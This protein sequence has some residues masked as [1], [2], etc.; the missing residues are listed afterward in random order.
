MNKDTSLQK[1]FDKITSDEKGW[2]K[3]LANAEGSFSKNQ[4]EENL[5]RLAVSR[6][7]LLKQSD[8]INRRRAHVMSVALV[9]GMITDHI[10][11]GVCEQLVKEGWLEH[12]NRIASRPHVNNGGGYLPTDKAVQEWPNDVSG[13]VP[14]NA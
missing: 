12:V 4:A 9:D 1:S 6:Q 13:T 2:R 10:S 3:L 7:T 14:G 11:D 5:R 8:A